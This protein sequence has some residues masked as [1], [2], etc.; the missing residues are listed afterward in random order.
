MTFEEH[1]WPFKVFFFVFT[2]YPFIAILFNELVQ[3]LDGGWL[4]T[5]KNAHLSR[6][7]RDFSDPSS[8]RRIL[9]DNDQ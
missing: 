1:S 9:L 6:A 8:L 3:S 7:S 5:V 2:D 4:I